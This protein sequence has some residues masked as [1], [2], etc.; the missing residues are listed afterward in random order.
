VRIA[1][2]RAAARVADMKRD[3]ITK[4][5]DPMEP[6]EPGPM[7]AWLYAADPGPPIDCFRDVPKNVN[8]LRRW[9]LARPE[10]ALLEDREFVRAACGRRVRVIYL[11]PFDTANVGACPQCVSMAQL[12]QDDPDEYDRQVRLRNEQWAQ[13]DAQRYDEYDEFDSDDFARQKSCGTDPI[14]D[15]ED[16]LP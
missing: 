15:E 11:H 1:D 5:W 10:T 16:V 14:D 12:W 8:R 13:R 6:A 2:S 7:H 9:I 3:P 4:Y